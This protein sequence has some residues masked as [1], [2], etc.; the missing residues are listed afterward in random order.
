[1]G[2]FKQ[3][4]Q[5]QQSVA[6]APEMVRSA[7]EM[8]QLAADAA[9]QQPTMSSAPVTAGSDAG[10]AIAGVTLARYAEICRLGTERGVTTT[11]GVAALAR[12]QGIDAGSWD[13]A[14]SG[15]NARFATDPDAAM[16][17]NRLWR[18]VG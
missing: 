2:L 7:M 8:Q 11:D 3:A 17:F 9:Q 10:E 12:E 13:A 14:M 5:M 4:K 1:M 6:A 15:W 16:T 18:G